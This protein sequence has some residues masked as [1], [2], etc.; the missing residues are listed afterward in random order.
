MKVLRL[1]SLFFGLFLALL[2]VS[3]FW[4]S[5]LLAAAPEKPTLPAAGTKVA[6]DPDSEPAHASQPWHPLYVEGMGTF[7]EVSTGETSPIMVE[8]EQHFIAKSG[9][10][11]VPMRIVSFGGRAFAEGIGET[12]F[13][14][15]ATRPV[16]SAIWE[17]RAGTEFPAIQEMRFH[18]FYTVEA[19][20]GKVLRSINPTVMRSN[21]V[22][23]FP[24]PPGTVYKL[25]RPVELEDVN[26]PGVVVARLLANTVVIPKQRSEREREQREQ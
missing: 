18:V 9:L 10:K 7:Q 15:D 20:P 26:E 4:A 12:R 23:G 2:G 14:L 17:K 13:W 5:S 16:T 25:V 21:D 24:P 3:T 8:V 11:T 19:L 22:R 6:C 1:R